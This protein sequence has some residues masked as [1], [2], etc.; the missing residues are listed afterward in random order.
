[1]TVPAS[2][3][4][5][6]PS[7]S[8]IL[9]AGDPAGTGGPPGEGEAAPKPPWYRR[10]GILLGGAVA[11]V[12]AI[13]IIT[14]LPQH[15]A[16]TTE[17]ANERTV[18][19]EID[20]DISPCT[21]A[22]QEAFQLYADESKPS[23]TAGNRARIP[24]LLRDDQSACS[25]TDN[26]IFDLSN[27][28]VPGSAAGRDIGA[29]VTTATTWASSDALAAIESIQTLISSPNNAKAKADLATA[30]RLA[31]E[32]RGKANSELA[33]ANVVLKA[34]L[35]NPALPRLPAPPS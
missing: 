3:T 19:S 10:R 5:P 24:G 4:G 1:M 27:I 13:T 26:A 22:V 23:L 30:E 6:Q 14:D 2:T 7:G 32:D 25:F 9:A 8:P 15:T 12:L 29:I 31:A 17:I 18:L 20:T 16:R 35:P 33:A 28:E 21:F 11:V 34:H